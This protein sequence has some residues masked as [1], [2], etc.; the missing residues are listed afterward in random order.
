MKSEG[1]Q[2]YR[3]NPERV[4]LTVHCPWHTTD[5]TARLKDKGFSG[6]EMSYPFTDT[7]RFFF[8]FHFLFHIHQNCQELHDPCSVAEVQQSQTQYSQFPHGLNKV[9]LSIMNKLD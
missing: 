1:A 2:R 8:C 5:P 7:L 4:L 3:D 9:V 6:Q